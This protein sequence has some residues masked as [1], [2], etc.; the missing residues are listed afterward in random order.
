MPKSFRISTFNTENLLHPGVFFA[1]RFYD[2]PYPPEVYEDKIDWI[3]RV[4]REGDVSLVGLQEIYSEQALKDIAARAEFPYIYAPGLE[5]GKN[6]TTSFEGRQE[7]R[8]PF[9]SLLSKFPIIAQQ[10]I[11]EFPGETRGIE[12]QAGE[13]ATELKRLPIT[14]FQRP[15]IQ[16]EIQLKPDIKAI[17]FVVHL[18]SKRPQFL[19]SERGKEQEPIVIA[20][21]K[22]R[23]LIIRAA[24]SVALRKLIVDATQNNNQPVILFGDLNDDLSAVTSEMIVGEEPH[25][26]AKFD[27]KKNA[28]DRLLYSVHDLEEQQ[29][30]R[31]ISYTHITN[32]RYELLDHIFV[33]QEFFHRNPASIAM[34]RS[35]R[36]F[37]D[38]LQDE[39]RVINP[40]RGPSNRSD[41]GIPVTEIEWRS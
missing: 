16:A 3:A 33:S 29:S 6:I 38:H 22:T 17:I 1:G 37:N 9:V 19:K 11:I 34:V 41:H 39:R 31:T 28:W 36:I 13:S 35:T 8:G 7:A 32:G 18:K 5:N 27:D 30:Y 24:E 40:E 14:H 12:I 20:A 23:S 10:A 2:K 26:F 4:L 25:R 15:V 21:G